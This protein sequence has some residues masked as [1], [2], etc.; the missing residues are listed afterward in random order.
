M[1]NFLS[2]K[3]YYSDFN[4]LQCWYCW[5][6]ACVWY[7][8][9]HRL[10]PTFL[11]T[12]CHWW[13]NRLYKLHIKISNKFIECHTAALL[14]RNKTLSFP[15]IREHSAQR[16]YMLKN[17][18]IIRVKSFGKFAF[19]HHLSSDCK[20]SW[21]SAACRPA[22]RVPRRFCSMLKREG[23]ATRAPRRFCRKKAHFVSYG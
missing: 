3:L 2:N 7:F 15:P 17:R 14:Y 21:N 22:T 18:F 16:V 20:N 5:R 13:T 10:S 11:I 6:F 9:H 8:R 19:F 4:Q 12:V 1:C 23:P